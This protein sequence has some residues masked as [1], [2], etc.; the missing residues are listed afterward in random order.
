MNHLRLSRD[1]RWLVTARSGQG[2][3]W[4]ATPNPIYFTYPL[5]DLSPLKYVQLNTV[6]ITSSSEQI[7]QWNIRASQS[8]FPIHAMKPSTGYLH[9]LSTSTLDA[10]V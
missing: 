6:H 1:G 7:H 2:G 10:D 3:W 4:L 9:A 5:P 8:I